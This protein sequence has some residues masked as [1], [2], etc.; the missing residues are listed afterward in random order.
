MS[1][2]TILSVFYGYPAELIALWCAVS[3][4]T[5]ASWKAGKG[6]PSRQALR[7][8]AL[9]RDERVLD[10][11]WRGWR[12]RKGTLVDPDGNATTQAQLRTYWMLIR[13]IH[14]APQKLRE[15]V[16]YTAWYLPPVK[17]T[18]GRGTSFWIGFRP[19]KLAPRISSV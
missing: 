16:L 18:P 15:L 8:F 3:P 9:H 13:G 2:R 11:Q 6:K 4:R 5:A 12:I 1:D 14:L 17:I 19:R 10:D 7:L